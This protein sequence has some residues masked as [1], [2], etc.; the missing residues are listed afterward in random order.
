MVNSPVACQIGSG[1]LPF[2]YAILAPA[3]RGDQPLGRGD[4]N[5]QQVVLANPEDVVAVDAF[6][7]SGITVSTSAIEV[8]GPH[9]NPLPRSRMIE[10]QN[11][12]S[13]PI[14]ISHRASFTD[15]DSF[16]LPVAVAGVSRRLS[17]PLLHNVSVYARAT[18]GSSTLRMIVY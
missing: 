4:R 2:T 13:N 14:F 16:Q 3:Q 12:G 11:T 9:I 1:T 18:G 5:G 15:L 8:V 17:L 7:A 6:V 10:F